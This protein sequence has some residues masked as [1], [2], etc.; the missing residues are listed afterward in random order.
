M[1]LPDSSQPII[2]VIRGVMMA[3]RWLEAHV[4]KKTIDRKRDEKTIAGIGLSI[5]FRSFRDNVQNLEHSDE[6][7]EDMGQKTTDAMV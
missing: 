4:K 1:G 2:I 7:E 3:I 5:N 6:S